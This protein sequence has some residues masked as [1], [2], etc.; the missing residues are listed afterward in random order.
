VPPFLSVF[1]ISRPIS[2]ERWK[3]SLSALS[4]CMLW[5]Q[6]GQAHS[7]SIECLELTSQDFASALVLSHESVWLTLTHE[8]LDCAVVSMPFGK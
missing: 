6:K 8:R 1:D 7:E 5:I 4:Q 3:R 2:C